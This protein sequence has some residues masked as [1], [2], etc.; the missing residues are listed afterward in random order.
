[1][2]KIGE[3]LFHLNKT[4]FT[5]HIKDQDLESSRDVK[6]FLVKELEDHNCGKLIQVFSIVDK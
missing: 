4:D 5:D 1:M 6:R 2:E 3:A